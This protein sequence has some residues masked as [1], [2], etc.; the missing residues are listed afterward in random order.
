MRS[1]ELSH[2]IA[3]LQDEIAALRKSDEE[4]R[5]AFAA[6]EDQLTELRYRLT[7]AHDALAAH[8]RQIEEKRAE[9]EKAVVREAHERFQQVMQEREAAAVALAESA[10][11]L[12]ERLA[13]LDRS[14]DAARAAWAAAQTVDAPPVSHLQVPPEIAT[15]P[16]VM[17]EAWERLCDEIRNR[18]NERFEDEL[19]DAA[20][21]SPLGSAIN[22]LP[23]HLREAARRRRHAFIRRGEDAGVESRIG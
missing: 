8:E 10:E 17:R 6:L 16:E 23:V 21:H 22:D 7:L 11:L 19:V 9:L 4:G 18:I 3:T 5:S 20:S 2:E 12:L 13:A 15:D 14:Q 1:D